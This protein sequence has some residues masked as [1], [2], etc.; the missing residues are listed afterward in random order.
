MVA[1]PPAPM[2]SAIRYFAGAILILLPDAATD[3]TLSPLIRR[4]SFSPPCPPRF[5]SF[6][7]LIILP[8]IAFH[9]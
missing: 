4:F 9:Y 1:P 8:L 6:T 2:F 5:L 7:P 3:I